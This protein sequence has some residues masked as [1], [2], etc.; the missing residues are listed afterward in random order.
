MVG[1]ILILMKLLLILLVLNTAGG[2]RVRIDASGKVGIGTTSPTRVFEVNSGTANAVA[3]FESTDSRALVEFKDNAGTASIGNI[4]NSLSFFPDNATETMRI[5]SSGNVGIGTTSP[6]Y[7]L[8]VDRG[9]TGD[10][11]HFEGQGS[12]HLRIGEASNVY[13]FRCS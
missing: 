8:H 7:P 6:S 10:I 5:D 1:M 13:V 4:G 12:V 9:A 3:R 2:E 11:A